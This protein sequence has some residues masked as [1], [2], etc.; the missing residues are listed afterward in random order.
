MPTASSAAI[1]AA[2]DDTHLKDRARALGAMLGMT[3]M[4][5]DA[6]WDRIVTRP[7]DASGEETIAM[8]YEYAA[9]QY[10]QAKAALPPAPG[11]NPSAVTDAHILYALTPHETPNP[12]EPGEEDR[13]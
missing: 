13:A 12:G 9:T 1:I 11:V 8:V 5:V 7:V 6:S 3:S 2:R 4:E 10:A